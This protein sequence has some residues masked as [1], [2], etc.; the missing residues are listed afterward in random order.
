MHYSN[1]NNPVDFP[2]VNVLSYLS[3]DDRTSI[4]HGIPIQYKNEILKL[5]REYGFKVK[6]RYRGPRV[7]NV[8]RGRINN[9]SS[10]LMGDATTFTVYPK[11]YTK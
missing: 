3:G 9:R 7:H 8:N 5:F 11:E 2:K 6:I 1:T 10:C 4:L